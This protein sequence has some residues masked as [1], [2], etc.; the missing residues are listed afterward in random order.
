[1]N[2]FIDMVVLA[3]ITIVL[4]YFISTLLTLLS[5]SLI[6]IY[7][8]KYMHLGYHNKPLNKK[9]LLIAYILEKYEDK[10][11]TIQD[12]VTYLQKNENLKAF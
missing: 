7:I 1:M 9:I 3:C 2:S 11:F 12:F 5:L 4:W 8:Q 10:L 6:H